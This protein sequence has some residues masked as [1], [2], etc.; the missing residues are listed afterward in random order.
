MA[1]S[2][3]GDSQS[4]DVN[5]MYTKFRQDDDEQLRLAD[6]A[7]RKVYALRVRKALEKLVF[8][9]DSEKLA[10]ELLNSD[11]PVEDILQNKK[12]KWAR[13]VKNHVLTYN[14]LLDFTMLLIIAPSGPST[15]LEKLTIDQEREARVLQGR[16]FYTVLTHNRKVKTV[17]MITSSVQTYRALRTCVKEFLSK[18]GVKSKRV[19]IVFNGHGSHSGHLHL[20]QEHQAI[21]TTTFIADIHQTWNECKISHKDDKGVSCYLPKRIHLILAQ[22]Y[23]YKHDI[24]AEAETVIDVIALTSEDHKETKYC[25]KLT[26]DNVVDSTHFDLTHCGRTLRREGDAGHAP[27]SSNNATGDR[28]AEHSPIDCGRTLRREGDDGHAPMSSNNST[29]DRS[30]EHSPI[31]KLLDFTGLGCLAMCI[32]PSDSATTSPI[33]DPQQHGPLALFNG[34]SKVLFSLSPK[35]I[36]DYYRARSNN[37]IIDSIVGPATNLA[38]APLVTQAS[39]IHNRPVITKKRQ[40]IGRKTR[41]IGD[42]PVKSY[43]MADALKSVTMVTNSPLGIH[44]EAG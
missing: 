31:M 18:H 25:Y 22:C 36:S 44:D 28:S 37:G 40:R 24:D 12:G 26:H 9:K 17:D 15:N 10:D 2:Q 41:A 19:Y 13:I 3:C 30:A 21:S 8:D 16:R 14:D 38:L 6:I 27:M 34:I 4:V 32:N 43:R 1:T 7:V 23:G 5:D 11:R 33:L 29:G 42:V 39:F 20:E 35:N